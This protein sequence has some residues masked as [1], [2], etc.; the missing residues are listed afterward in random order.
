MRAIASVSALVFLLW[1]AAG[2]GQ[3]SGQIRGTVVDDDGKALV[4]VKVETTT[5]SAGS[6]AATTDKKGQ[7]RFSLVA[8][9]TYK[10]T[11]NLESYSS[12]E[13]S[14]VVGLDRTVTV[15]AKLFR[16]TK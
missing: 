10:V 2:F 6:R 7:F 16:L 12:V 1:A 3:T 11:F 8:P 15:N 4:N 9:G 14:A 13:K 5:P